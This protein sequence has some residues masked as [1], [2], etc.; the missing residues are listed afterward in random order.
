MPAM[1]MFPLGAVLLPHMPLRLRVFEER[2][3]IMMSEV[4]NAHGGEFGVVLIERGHEVGGGEV[5]FTTGTIAE[6]TDLGADRGYVTLEAR[7][8]RRF[9]VVEWQADKPYPQAEVVERPEL[10]W[11]RSLEPLRAEAEAVVR[12]AL[13]QASEFSE[14]IWPADLE[15][16]PDP[17]AAAWQLAGIAPLGELDQ[18]RLLRSASMEELLRSVI[19]LTTDAQRG[20]FGL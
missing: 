4:I 9:D 18:I 19:E 8:A 16:S 11:V 2:Y 14:N 7:G 13:A 12:R 3:L 10:V 15:L 20:L 6:I 1:P 5:R 17:V